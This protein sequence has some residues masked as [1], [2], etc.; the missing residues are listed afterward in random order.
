MKMGAGLFWG[1]ILIVIGLSIIFKVVFGISIMRIIIAV[2]F[3]LIG[4]KI[5]IGKSSVNISSNESDVIFGDRVF[6]EFPVTNTE[7][8]TIFGKSTYNFKDAS[9]PTDKHIELE[10]NTIF[11]NSTLILPPGLPVRIKGEAVFGAVKLP[12]ENTAVFGDADYK[13]DHDSTMTDFVTIKASA[14][15]GNMDIIQKRV[16]Y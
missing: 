12:N 9:I 1:L 6:K 8:N 11:G 4:L 7:Y 14:V 13:S 5:L 15:F 16:E 2:V 3:I 10:F